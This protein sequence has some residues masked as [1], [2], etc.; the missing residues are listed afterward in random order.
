MRSQARFLSS[1]Q[2]RWRGTGKKAGPPVFDDF[3][4]RVFR[5]DVPNRAWLMEIME[6]WISEGKLYC[7]AIKDVFS[8]RI[9]GYS[10]SDWMTA[11]PAVEAVR[12]GLDC[13]GE[14]AGCIL[15]ADRGNEC[16]SRAMDRGLR[17]HDMVGSM[18]GVVAAA[19]ETTR[20]W[21]ASRRGFNPSRSTSSDGRP[22][23]TCAS[24]SASGSS[25]S[26]TV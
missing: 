5:A 21:R 25:G 3:V 26:T 24:P 4:Q 12:N 10:I 9:V 15:H 20:Q 17:R 19:P 8:N 11:K 16:R 2:R 23:R 14:V 6:H 7:C 22:G 13:R 18:G 1:A